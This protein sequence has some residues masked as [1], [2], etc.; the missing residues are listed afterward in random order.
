[1]NYIKFL[2]LNQTIYQNLQLPI[3]IVKLCKNF[4][5]KFKMKRIYSN[6]DYDEI[7]TLKEIPSADCNYIYGGS[8]INDDPQYGQNYYYWYPAAGA[9]I[10]EYGDGYYVKN[11]DKNKRFYIPKNHPIYKSDFEKQE[12]TLKQIQ[13]LII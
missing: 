9:N 2:T 10:D 1:M 13:E 6:K 7:K 3:A 12:F 4:N 8:Y 11:Y 5:A